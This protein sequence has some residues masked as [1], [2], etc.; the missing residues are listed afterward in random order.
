MTLKLDKVL[1][2]EDDED[3]RYIVR[4]YFRE[5][6]LR[7]DEAVSVKAAL[8]LIEE[9]GNNYQLIILDLGLLNG[10]GVKTI[11]AIHAC[12]VAPIV[13]YTGAHPEILDEI[14]KRQRELG[15]YAIIEKNTF[16]ADRIRAFI[17]DAVRTW[18]EERLTMSVASLVAQIDS[19]AVHR[20]RVL[21]GMEN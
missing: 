1:H 7:I 8:K 2:V 21:H 18:R 6:W 3:I 16:S 14:R 17:G 5:E 12:T 9:T 20:R 15:V 11:E 19:I 4:H 13:L 10:H